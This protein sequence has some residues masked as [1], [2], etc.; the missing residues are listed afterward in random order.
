MKIVRK[1]YSLTSRAWL[2]LL[3][4]FANLEFH[5]LGRTVNPFFGCRWLRA[6]QVEFTSPISL[7]HELYIRN[8]GHLSL[9]RSCCLGS[10]TRIWNYN[11]I[12]VGDDFLC[13]GGLNMNTA[14]HDP[15]SLAFVGKEIRVGNRVWCGLNVTILSGVTIGDDVVIGSG[16]VVISD[17]PSNCIA[18]G[19]PAKKVRDLNRPADLEI[20]RLSSIDK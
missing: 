4:S 1:F 5:V 12:S 3:R 9:G 18:V 6:M 8:S 2:V 20:W 14:S 13:A 16:S 7:G 15:V 19:V 10:F 17:L 11:L